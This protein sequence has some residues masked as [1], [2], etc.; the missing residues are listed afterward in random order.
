MFKDKKSKSDPM[1]SEFK[2]LI[3]LAENKAAPRKKFKEK[4]F[5]ELMESN[6]LN[7]QNHLVSNYSFLEKI[8]FEK[9]WRFAIPL[10]LVI[11]IIFRIST[12]SMFDKLIYTL[13]AGI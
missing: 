8:I 7:V 9:P 11:S 13:F 6:F 4:L 2:N 12:G 3:K 1:D 5:F 10:S